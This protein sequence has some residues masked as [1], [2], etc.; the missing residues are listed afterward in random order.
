MRIAYLGQMADVATENGIS[1]KIRMQAAAWIAAGHPVRYFALTPTTAVWPG[2]TPLQTEVI[3]R[4]AGLVRAVRSHE[5]CRRI[6][7]WRPDIIYFRYAH[8]S[9]GLPALFHAVPAAAEI[10]SDDTVEYALTLSGPKRL[11]HRLT[12]ERILRAVRA[13]IPVTHELAA[14]FAGFEKPSEVIGNS[15]DFAEFPPLPPPCEAQGRRLVF[16]GSPGTPWHGL[17]R[18][19][20]IAALFPEVAIDV[21]GCAEDDWRAAGAGAVPANVIFH[22]TLSHDRYLPLLHAATAALGTLG[23]YRKGMDEA[24]PLKVREYLAL[25]LPVIAGYQDTDV[26]PEADYYLRLPNNADALAPW[27]ERIAA[28][29]QHWQGRRVARASVAHL[30]TGVKEAR[31][32]AFMEK[33][34]ASSHHV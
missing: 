4:G 21:V 23:L 10:N 34:L 1:K 13:F 18:V 25:G 14:R 32:L 17:D 12:R 20:A 3:R 16:V 2:L 9:P 6:R 28:F 15:F 26:P 29:L 31:R 27:R 19:G 30:D 24:C 33:I 5:L 11:Y 8:H 22:G 7:A